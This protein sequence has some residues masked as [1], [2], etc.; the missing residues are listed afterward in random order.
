MGRMRK[1]GE[2]LSQNPRL[3]T[4][5]FVSLGNPPPSVIKSLMV[6]SLHGFSGCQVKVGEEPRWV[7]SLSVLTSPWLSLHLEGFITFGKASLKGGE[8]KQA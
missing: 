5:G 1:E 6:A 3:S 4:K 8:G 7:R 2:K